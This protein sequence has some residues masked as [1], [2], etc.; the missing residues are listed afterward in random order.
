MAARHGKKTADGAQAFTN[1]AFFDGHVGFYE[2]KPFTRT[3]T[4]QEISAY[5]GATPDNGLVAS[6]RETIFYINKQ[7]GK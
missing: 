4:A 1:L 2:T 7:H 3:L 6:Y 5:G